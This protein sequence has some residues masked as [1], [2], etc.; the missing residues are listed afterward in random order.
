MGV[1]AWI[2]LGLLVGTAARMVVPGRAPHG[3]A[4]TALIGVAGALLGGLLATLF[5]VSDTYGF[6]D[7]VTWI[8]AITGAVVL[9]FAYH[10]ITGRR[11]GQPPARRAGGI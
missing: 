11:S 4:I 7:L 10:L 2:I 8:T 3:L 5:G 6:F 9:L 1:I